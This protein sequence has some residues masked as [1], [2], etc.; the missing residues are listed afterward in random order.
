LNFG[1]ALR[2][3]CNRRIPWGTFGTRVQQGVREDKG[4]KR[5]GK[6]GGALCPRRG[7]RERTEDSFI[8]S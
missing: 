8:F 6:S 4:G 3:W 2:V 5:I 1:I 7:P